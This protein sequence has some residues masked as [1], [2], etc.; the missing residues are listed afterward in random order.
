M[1]YIEDR[2]ILITGAASGIGRLLAKQAAARGAS[3]VACDISEE[4]LQVTV[5]AIAENSGKAIGVR[6]DVTNVDDLHAAVKA[7]VEKFG[8][9]DVLVN[10]AGIMPHA[11]FADH[12]KAIDAW[13]LCLDIN[14]KGVLNGIISVHDQM[15]KQGKGHVVNVSSICG[16][17]PVAGSAV[18]GASK[19]AVNYLGES[20]RKESQG[21]IKVTTVRPTGVPGTGLSRTVINEAA[22]MHILGENA[23]TYGGNVQALEEGK[24]QADWSD[25]DNIQYLAISPELLSEQILYAIDQP[26]GVSIGDITVRASGDMYVV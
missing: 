9:L 1:S 15:I 26:W 20:L 2:V 3:I 23:L 7:G 16:N 18:Y 21:K 13:N 6:A 11:Y 4:E 25:S 14:I 8:R 10:N 22:G 12:E 5:S 19:A 17:A 24:G